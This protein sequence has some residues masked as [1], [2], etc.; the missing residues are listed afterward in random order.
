MDNISMGSCALDTF[1][2]TF[3]EM[4]VEVGSGITFRIR[5]TSIPFVT[6]GMHFNVAFRAVTV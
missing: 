5:L 6:R 3:R 4:Q 2:I 1:L